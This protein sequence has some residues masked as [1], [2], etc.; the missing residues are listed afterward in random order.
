M[1]AIENMTLKEIKELKEK[2]RNEFIE[3]VKEFLKNHPDIEGIHL[4]HNYRTELGLFPI[5]EAACYSGD[6]IYLTM[7]KI[8]TRV[9]DVTLKG[10][11][12]CKQE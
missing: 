7:Y 10:E 2:Y 6:S 9:S 11:K 4:Y 8:D 1:K 5:G 12:L 3:L